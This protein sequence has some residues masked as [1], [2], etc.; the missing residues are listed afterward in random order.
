[1]T[2]NLCANP[3]DYISRHPVHK[4]GSKSVAEEYVHYNCNN[5]V[6]KATTLNEVREKNATD[7]VMQRLM[8]TIQSGK[9]QS[10]VT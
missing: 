5:A 9:S 4:C 6:P 10:G 7:D 3:A 2:M 1:M 8:K